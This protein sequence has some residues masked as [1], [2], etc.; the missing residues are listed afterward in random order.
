M[1]TL[2]HIFIGLFLTTQL[3]GQTTININYLSRTPFSIKDSI[4]PS[5]I[6]ID[7]INEYLFWLKS[8][9]KKDISVKYNTYSDVSL[10]KT[11]TKNKSNNAIGLGACI[12]GSDKTGEFDYSVPYMKNLSFCITNGN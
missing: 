9:K 2:K 12:T 7:L 1:K 8:V 10:F 6:E 3:I 4:S 11:D 5:G